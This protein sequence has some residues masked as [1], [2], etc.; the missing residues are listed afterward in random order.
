MKPRVCVAKLSMKAVIKDFDIRL[1]HNYLNKLFVDLA[2]NS[3]DAKEHRGNRFSNAVVSH[4]VA[5]DIACLTAMCTGIQ[6][7]NSA[8]VQLYVY[9][10]Y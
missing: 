3:F 4:F 9:C 5:S 1:H 6:P 8:H 7:V 10:C 2:Q